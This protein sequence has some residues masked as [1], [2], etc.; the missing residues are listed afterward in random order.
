MKEQV[1]HTKVKCRFCGKEVE[2]SKLLYGKKK[3]I[4]ICEDCLDICN[5]IVEDRK[6]IAELPEMKEVPKPVDLKAKL[7]EY[8]VGQD[9]AKKIISVAVYN[10][11]KRI[12]KLKNS[13][14]QKANICLIGS[15]GSGKTLMARTV[16]KLLDV[17]IVIADATTFT[18]AG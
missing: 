2:A 11:Y 14:V 4:T 8:I 17:P 5:S 16:A 6:A 10:H 3:D 7:D 18:S 12:A 15:S 13:S 1:E 9:R